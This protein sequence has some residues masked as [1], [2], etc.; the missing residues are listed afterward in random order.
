MNI[1]L[2]CLVRRSPAWWIFP[3]YT[4]SMHIF[5]GNGT[6]VIWGPCVKLKARF[7]PFYNPVCSI[8]AQAV[9]ENM[10]SLLSLLRESV[11]LN[12]AP[13]GHFLLLGSVFTQEELMS[14]TSVWKQRTDSQV[15]VSLKNT[16]ILIIFIIF[17]IQKHFLLL[18]GFSM[19]SSTGCPTS[20]IRR[21]QKIC[22]Q[23]AGC[24][25]ASDGEILRY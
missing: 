19:T 17:G 10:A 13:P 21:T 15:L 12:L 18:A 2:S 24:R 4:L 25:S 20:T 11:Q 5:K 9:Q 8:P 7:K 22:R 14:Q 1:F 3:C 23:V 16:K 6:H